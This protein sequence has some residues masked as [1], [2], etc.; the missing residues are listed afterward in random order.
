VN[1]PSLP[2]AIS[3]ITSPT[4]TTPCRFSF[5]LPGPGWPAR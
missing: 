1:L 4:H 2:R 5:M 3:T